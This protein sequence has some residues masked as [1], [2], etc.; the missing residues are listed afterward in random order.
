MAH[1]TMIPYSMQKVKFIL[2]Y[3]KAALHFHA[4]EDGYSLLPITSKKS[5]TQVQDFLIYGASV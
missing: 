1:A 4:V 2:S 5:C 3:K